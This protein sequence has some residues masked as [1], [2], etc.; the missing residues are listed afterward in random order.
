MLFRENEYFMACKPLP[1]IENQG[2]KKASSKIGPQNKILNN[3]NSP[4]RQIVIKSAFEAA[5]MANQRYFI[6]FLHL[7]R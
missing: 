4:Q 5:G 2:I 1:K 7:S 6:I 3:K